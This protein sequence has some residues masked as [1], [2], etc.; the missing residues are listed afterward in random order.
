MRS[1]GDRENTL[2]GFILKVSRKLGDFYL[3]GLAQEKVT[4]LLLFLGGECVSDFLGKI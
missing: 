4:F 3:S 2:S 1:N